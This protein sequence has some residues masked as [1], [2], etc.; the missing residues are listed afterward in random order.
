MLLAARFLK[1]WRRPN[2]TLSAKSPLNKAIALILE[3]HMEGGVQMPN[4]K[5]LLAPSSSVFFIGLDVVCMV[6]QEK[7]CKRL[8]LF[9][10]L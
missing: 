9:E 6:L 10:I 4:R 7:Q 1:Y 8:L 2:P 3:S 5:G